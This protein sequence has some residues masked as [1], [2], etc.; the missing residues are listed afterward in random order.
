[1]D[2][3][4]KEKQKEKAS[5][6]GSVLQSGT[7]QRLSRFVHDASADSDD[8][9]PRSSR[10]SRWNKP[11]AR[12]SK[13]ATG[14]SRIS[15]AAFVRASTAAGRTTKAVRQSQL[16]DITEQPNHSGETDK[17]APTKSPDAAGFRD[18]Y[19]ARLRNFQRQVSTQRNSRSSTSGK[20]AVAALLSNKRGDRI[21]PHPS[22]AAGAARAP[23]ADA[24][25][26]DESAAAEALAAPP[27]APEKSQSYWDTVEDLF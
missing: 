22:S 25:G 2:R 17:D 26:A 4:A 5:R 9:K 16:G 11:M 19:T 1:L 12:A 13:F 23:G 24:P 14:V 7:L 20:S 27:V 6:W 18:S 10:A 15:S 3:G 8:A 21:A